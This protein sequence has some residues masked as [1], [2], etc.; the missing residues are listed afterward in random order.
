MSSLF[1]AGL[2][3]GESEAELLNVHSSSVSCSDRLPSVGVHRV[4]DIAEDWEGDPSS[5]LMLL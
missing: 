5:Q 3:K 2:F 4:N 1:S